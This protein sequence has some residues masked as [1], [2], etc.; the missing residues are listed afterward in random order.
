[1][2]WWTQ[3]QKQAM[4]LLRFHRENTPS[5]QPGYQGLSTMV[6]HKNSNRKEARLCCQLGIRLADF[7]GKSTKEILCL[8][9]SCEG[10]YSRH[11]HNTDIG[12]VCFYSGSRAS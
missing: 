3:Q 6:L 2:D 1:M 11:K 12:E 7:R 10:H 9:I 5:H 4:D 8:L